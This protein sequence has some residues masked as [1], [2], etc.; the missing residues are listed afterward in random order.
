MLDRAM[1][2]P[3]LHEARRR[4]LRPARGRVLEIGFGSG[5][6]LPFYPSGVTE[7]VGVDPDIDLSRRA[8][9]RLSR[10][11]IDVRLVDG[12]A[13]F[14]PFLNHSFDTVVTTLTLCSV[15][16]PLHVL[17]EIQRVLVPKGQWLFLEH[18]LDA[19]SPI[20]T[21]QRRLSGINAC[22]CGGCRL[23]RD[24]ASLV[25]RAGF[26]SGEMTSFYLPEVP[27]FGGYM[28]SGNANMSSAQ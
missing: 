5:A 20:S 7:I 21:W 4:A 17:T 15:E 27:R 19:R 9:E 10:F 12:F 11:P 28:T 3:R 1:N 14:L 6:N 8:A 22:L 24:I 16:N 25:G 18:G 23:D 2:H 13:E 26:S